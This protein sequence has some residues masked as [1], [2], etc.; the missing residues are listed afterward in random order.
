M[1]HSVIVCFGRGKLSTESDHVDEIRE[2]SFSVLVKDSLHLTPSIA[3]RDTF[4][5]RLVL[6]Q[7]VFLV[8]LHG[9]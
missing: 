5:G 4:H 6:D 1:I 2:G 7:A 9:R 8:L 3:G